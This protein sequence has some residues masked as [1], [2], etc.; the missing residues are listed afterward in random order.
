M[1]HV[2]GQRRLLRLQ[3][4]GELGWR[5]A[6]RFVCGATP[7]GRGSWQLDEHAACPA[8]T[9]YG[10][11]LH[12]C[13]MADARLCSLRELAVLDAARGTGCSFDT[14]LVWTSDRCT[15]THTASTSAHGRVVAPGSSRATVGVDAQCL[16]AAAAG[17]GSLAHVR[18]CA[19]AAHATPRSPTPCESLKWKLAADASPQTAAAAVCGATRDSGPPNAVY[20]DKC[21]LHVNLTTQ[22]LNC[23][24][25][26]GRLCTAREIRGGAG[27]GT[28]CGVNKHYTCVP[29]LNSDSHGSLPA[30]LAR[31]HTR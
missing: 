28:G 1:H 13:H 25:L 3:T 5:L 16:P 4:C 23:D 17:A 14:K 10:E 6:N 31:V 12:V 15:P 27:L 19:N 18:C 7:G 11:A 9:T 24:L 30:V 2:H 22:L 21:S 26:G 29:N 8:E 20:G